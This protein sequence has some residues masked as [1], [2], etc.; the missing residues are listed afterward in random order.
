MFLLIMACLGKQVR[1]E[2]V[3]TSTDLLSWAISSE[4]TSHRARVY[5]GLVLYSDDQKSEQWSILAMQDP[6]RFVREEAMEAMIIRGTGQRFSQQVL[7]S[8]KYSAGEKCSSAL[9]LF[10]LNS[11]RN[12]GKWPIIPSS[13]SAEDKAICAFAASHILSVRDP[14]K[15]ILE[16]GQVPLSLPL[17]HLLLNYSL[18]EDLQGLEVGIEW[19][20]EESRPFL[21]TVWAIQQEDKMGQLEDEIPIF[22]ELQCLDI[23]DFLWKSKLPQAYKVLR[24]LKKRNDFCGEM[25]EVGLIANNEGRV[26]ALLKFITT[27]ERAYTIF[28]LKALQSVKFSSSKEQKKYIKAVQNLLMKTEEP[29]VLAATA[30]CLGVIGYRNA[31]RILQK[32]LDKKIDS[33]VRIEI[34]KALMHIE[35]RSKYE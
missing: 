27:E 14:L 12:A 23:V 19:I 4:V 15:Q 21:L 8:E 26:G 33:W 34:E 5:Q 20:E 7:S 17:F 2:R 16:E 30:E 28:A 1:F 11:E 3:Q 6:S 18:A 24:Q 10:S 22:S 32:Q 31:H 35:F 29:T 9:Y 25:A 13:A